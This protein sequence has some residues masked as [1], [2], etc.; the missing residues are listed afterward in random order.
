MNNVDR[1][2]T[3]PEAHADFKVHK[4]LMVGPTGTIF[5][6]ETRQ[7]GSVAFPGFHLATDHDIRSAEADPSR[8]RQ[9]LRVQDLPK[10]PSQPRLK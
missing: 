4:K 10:V 5:P 6:S 1:G 3:T 2:I 9:G 8:L 7:D